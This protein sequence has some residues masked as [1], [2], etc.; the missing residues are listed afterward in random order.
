MTFAGQGHKFGNYNTYEYSSQEVLLF[1]QNLPLASE[2][3]I[4]QIADLLLKSIPA[5]QVENL[6]LVLAHDISSPGG[7]HLTFDL[8]FAGYRI[9]Q[10]QAKAN[11]SHHNIVESFLINAPLIDQWSE[12]TIGSEEFQIGEAAHFYDYISSEFDQRPDYSVEQVI[13]I[14]GNSPYFALLATIHDQKS[15]RLEEVLVGKDEIKWTQDLNCYFL[16]DSTAQALVFL[17]DPLT[18]AKSTYQ[19]PYL[20]ND[21]A[22]GVEINAE[23]MEVNIRTDFTGGIFSLTNEI[24]QIRDFD[25]PSTPP[26]TSTAPEFFYTRSEAGFE[27]ANA[28]YH[29]TAMRE[30]LIS[31]GFTT[32]AANQI[33]VDPHALNGDD[34]S[35]FSPTNPPRLMFGEGGVDDAEDADVVVHEFGHAISFSAAPNTNS[36]IERQSMDEGIGDYVAATYSR[37]IDTFRWF[38]IFSWD[39]HNQYWSGRSAKADKYYPEDINNSIHSNGEIWST[40]WM[41]IWEVLGKETTDQLFFQTLYALTGNLKMNQAAQLALES[42]TMLFN[43][44]NS[45]NMIPVL[46]KRGLLS[47]SYLDLCRDGSIVA[48]AGNDSSIC[49]K[50]RIQLGNEAAIA[51]YSY[52]WS[53]SAGID[54]PNTAETSGR[55]DSASQI[56]LTVTNEAGFFNTDTI[57]ISVFGCPE[58]VLFYNTDGF[59]R[60]GEPITI[61]FPFGNKG[62]TISIVDMTGKAVRKY[63][64]VGADRFLLPPGDLPSGGYIIRVDNGDERVSQKTVR[65]E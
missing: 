7:R 46:V 20:D 36:G 10:S 38:D 27:D 64:K 41:E 49:R 6:N 65:V 24:V 60:A 52:N 25:A 3:T 8:Y 57:N 13:G 44:A 19:S 47:S 29:V 26:V 55:I 61:F 16:P 42:D 4:D 56:V 62:S 37:S 9:Y 34:N 63:E 2:A 43:G 54:D 51:G 45:C 30:Y 53:P 50:S 28:F 22:D 40:V 15:H 14:D 23:R 39:G 1:Q 11:I 32:L 12:F 58:N 21:D 48:N 59:L 17:P 33:W 35:F 18:T 31:I 5:L